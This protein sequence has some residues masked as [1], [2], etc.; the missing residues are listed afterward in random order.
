MLYWLGL[1]TSP[2]VSKHIFTCMFMD[3]QNSQQQS[4]SYV[5]ALLKQTTETVGLL[6]PKLTYRLVIQ[7]LS[8]ASPHSVGLIKFPFCTTIGKMRMRMFNCDKGYSGDSKLWDSGKLKLEHVWVQS[9]YT[10]HEIW[11]PTFFEKGTDRWE[12]FIAPLTCRLTSQVTFTHKTFHCVWKSQ[13]N[14]SF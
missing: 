12:E 5:T 4:V 1:L 10:S 9:G 3:V 7:E 11:Y 6:S 2:T 8:F 13:E 14:T